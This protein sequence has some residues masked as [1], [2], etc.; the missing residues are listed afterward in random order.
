L[1]ANA[2]EQQW[3]PSIPGWQRPDQAVAFGEDA[4]SNHVDSAPLTLMME[5]SYYE[6]QT[7][8][9]V[10]VNITKDLPIPNSPPSTNSPPATSP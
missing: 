10:Y 4:N 8:Q 5:E 3:T 7:V 9:A 2:E 1:V 6:S